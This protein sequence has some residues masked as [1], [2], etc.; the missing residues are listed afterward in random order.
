MKYAEYGCLKDYIVDSGP[1]K[2]EAQIKVIMS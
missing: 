2:E 1:L